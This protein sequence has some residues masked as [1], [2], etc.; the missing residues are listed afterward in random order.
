MRVAVVLHVGSLAPLVELLNDARN[1]HLAGVP[2]DLYANLAT[3]KVDEAAAS[4]L[5]RE[6]YPQA[7]VR[8][9]ENRGMDIGGFLKLLP[10]VMAATPAYDY[11]LKLHTKSDLRW[12]RSLIV[13]IC[14]SPAQV[15]LCLGT[16]QR[17]PLIGMIGSA[18]HLYR[19]PRFRRPNYHYLQQ[20]TTHLQ[21]PYIDCPFIG[22]TMFWMRASLLKRVFEKHDLNAL[23]S[24]LNTPETFCCNWYFTNYRDRGVTTLVE[25]QRHWEVHGQKAGRYRN[26]LDARE[27]GSTHYIPDG[28]LEHAWERL[29]GLIVRVRGLQV[30][31]F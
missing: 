15:K 8:T 4:A 1:V 2:F 12:R 20:L 22:G 29:F 27:H 16:L 10:L 23:W 11:I 28:M 7:V 5:I 14:G 25:A 18:R 19:E 6:A 24:Q 13:P 31:G 17:Q 9:S 21:L 3:G 30:I 26:C